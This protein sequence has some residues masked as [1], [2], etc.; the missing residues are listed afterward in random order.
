MGPASEGQPFLLVQYSKGQNANELCCSSEGES[1]L[2]LP[3][4]NPNQLRAEKRT[5]CAGH[6]YSS[7]SL[8]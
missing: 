2:S 1:I 8:F 7:C 6:S 3:P 4:S 5:A